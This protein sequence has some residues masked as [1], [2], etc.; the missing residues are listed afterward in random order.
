MQ[1]ELADLPGEEG[2]ERRRHAYGP[3]FLRMGTGVR[4]SE[5]CRFTHPHRIVLDDDA[6]INQS[7][8]IYGS[9]GVI[10][11]RHARIGPRLFIHSANHDLTQDGRAFFERGYTYETV[12]IGDNC[13]ISANVSILPG[14]RLAAGT[15]VACGAVVKRGDYPDGCRIMG[16]PGRVTTAQVKPPAAT[17][18]IAILVPP[19]G[20]YRQAAELLIASLGLPQ[21]MAFSEGDELPDSVHSLLLVG[22]QEW[23]PHQPG[24]ISIWRLTGK[25]QCIEGAVTISAAGPDGKLQAV[26]IPAAHRHSLAPVPDPTLS[27]SD[28]ACSLT[29][30]YA[31]KRLRKRRGRLL[32][33]ER[34]DLYLSLWILLRLKDPSLDCIT[35]ELASLLPDQTEQTSANE[36]RLGERLGKSRRAN[37]NKLDSALADVIIDLA[38]ASDSV[39]QAAQKV[40]LNKFSDR[41]FLVCP[42]LLT[43]LALKGK[44]KTRQVLADHIRSL[45]TQPTKGSQLTHCGLAASVLGQDD[46]L[47]QCEDRLYSAE[48]FDEQSGSVRSAAGS[49]GSFYSPALMALL[50]IAQRLRGNEQ[51]SLRREESRQDPIRWTAP[52]GEDAEWS[53]RSGLQ[54]GSL[55]NSD[56][57]LV[58]RSLLDN[59][60]QCLRVPVVEGAQ[61]ELA[62][63]NY[64]PIAG[65]IEAI[66]ASLFRHMQ[67]AAGRP[68]VRVSPWPHPCRAALSIRYD[69]DR[70]VQAQ[71]V[72]DIIQIQARRLNSPCASWYAI[73]GTPFGDKLR[74]SLPRSLQEA[75]VHAL[76]RADETADLGVTHHSAPNSEY[77]RGRSTIEALEHGGAAYGEMLA[78]QLSRPRPGWID[79]DQ[80]GRPVSIWMTP[81]H[82]PLEGSTDDHDLTYFDRLLDQFRSLIADGGHVILGSHPDLNLDPLTQLLDREDLENIWCANV[83]AVV[84]RCRQLT[85]YGA[86]FQAG[87]TE[88][89]VELVACNTIADVQIDIDLPDGSTRT[90]CTQLSANLPRAINW[91]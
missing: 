43:A 33:G 7:A 68:L 4:I 47:L 39:R 2:I 22:P 78:S 44:D 72:E 34:L 69:I 58:S 38:R 36:R 42:E 24:N 64:R 31:T 8:L 11:G 49:V 20:H 66:W 28:N 37:D 27:N 63:D 91:E 35:D 18:S 52:G 41:T 89:G 88:S 1:A 76:S 57:R 59:W 14:A 13:L 48:F 45:I 51:V 5:G 53:I 19:D 32:D 46:L 29:L 61:Y 80:G 26:P 12:R 67:H 87:A 79:D 83:A 90:I 25:G 55:I 3:F 82:F 9:G 71:Q 86:V 16:V 56:Q 50:L 75:G 70:L 73:P 74:D 54:S 62:A 6:R 85:S 10:I 81:I 84:Q 77:W 23:S 17:P 30:Y 21:V 60:I 15:F 65:R 40:A